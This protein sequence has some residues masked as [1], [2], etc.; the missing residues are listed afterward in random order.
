MGNAMTGADDND[1]AR[2]IREAQKRAGI[3]VPYR[4]DDPDNELDEVMAERET[5]P[6]AN[7]WRGTGPKKPEDIACNFCGK[8]RSKAKSLVAGRGTYICDTCITA[9]T[10]ALPLPAS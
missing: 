3:H 7:P 6:A 5:T 4:S 1:F 8:A 2:Q 9:A 10:K